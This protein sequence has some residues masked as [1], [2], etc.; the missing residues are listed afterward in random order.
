[1]YDYVDKIMAGCV[2]LMIVVRTWIDAGDTWLGVGV[3]AS[4]WWLYR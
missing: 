1:M 3:S 2:E 4:V